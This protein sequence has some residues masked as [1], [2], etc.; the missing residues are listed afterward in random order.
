MKSITKYFKYSL[1]LLFALSLYQCEENYTENISDNPKIT[2]SVPT[3][4]GHAQYKVQVESG[5]DVT[6]PV[7]ISSSSNLKEFK[8]TKTLNLNA[9][10]SFGDNGVMT[11]FNSDKGKDF[12]YS[13]TYIPS[14]QDV[15]QLVGFTFTA[16]NNDGSVSESDLTLVVTLSPRDNLPRKRWNLKSVLWVTNPDNPNQE[17]IS[18]CEKDN[19]MLLNADGTMSVDYGTDTG[20]G[21]CAYDGLTV[22]DSW[23]LT[24]DDQYFIRT[25]HGLF[26]PDVEVTDTFVVRTLTVQQFAI[27]QTVDLSVF[28]A[29]TNEKFLYVYDAGP[30]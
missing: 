20:S 21:N 25:S 29:G 6:V 11:V 16:V 13:F 2:L 10:P 3:A 17:S 28:G 27:E 12:D 9:D 4:P 19:S 5:Y 23:G 8:I 18:D 7:K 30:R 14:T 24:P 22:Y 15:D 1:V 26:T